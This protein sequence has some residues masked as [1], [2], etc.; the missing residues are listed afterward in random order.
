[1]SERRRLGLFAL[2]VVV[3][4]AVAGVAIAASLGGDGPQS[5]SAGSRTVLTDARAQDRQ[6]VVF[7]SLAGGA[8]QQAGDQVAVEAADGADAAAV[9]APLNCERVYFAAGRGLCLARGSGF[10]AGYR[11]EIFGP[12]FKVLHTVPVSGVPSRARVSP[13]GRYGSVTLFVTGHSYAAA[14]A[15]ST[16]T[17]LIDLAEGTKIADLEQF[18]ITRDGEPVTA[19]DLNFWGVTFARDSDRFYATM[20]TGGKTYLLQ[21]SVGRRTARVL[22]ENVEC[23]SLSPDGARVAYKKRGSSSSAPWRLT[24]LDLATMRETPLAE[25][26]SVDDQ[27][28]WLDDGRVLYGVDDAVWTAAADGTGTPK[29]FLAGAASPAVVRW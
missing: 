19:V 6:M 21:G 26:R 27:V 25:T 1:M 20:A 12:D 5:A 8:G 18:R 9:K 11:A 22:H 16:Q 2:L 23:P 28:E 24:V 7:R 4:A 29:R 3:S 14:G 17:T 15:F 10:A 13:D